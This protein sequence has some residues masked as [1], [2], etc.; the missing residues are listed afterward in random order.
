MTV[1]TVIYILAKWLGWV[2]LIGALIYAAL[3]LI[4]GEK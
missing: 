3:C 2:L 4:E 1:A